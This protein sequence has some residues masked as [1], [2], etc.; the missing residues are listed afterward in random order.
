MFFNVDECRVGFVYNC[1]GWMLDYEEKEG[2]VRYPLVIHFSFL[3]LSCC[4]NRYRSRSIKR[5]IPKLC[6]VFHLYRAW[7]GRFHLEHDIHVP[8]SYNELR[9]EGV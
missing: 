3:A 7:N 1:H 6:A 2:V 4:T 8:L 9:L 5:L